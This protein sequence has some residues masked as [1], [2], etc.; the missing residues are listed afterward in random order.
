MYVYLFPDIYLAPFVQNCFQSTS[1]K[2]QSPQ[3]AH[4]KIMIK[5]STRN[6]GTGAVRTC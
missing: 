3:Y 6:V 1:Q 2:S 5:I 4:I